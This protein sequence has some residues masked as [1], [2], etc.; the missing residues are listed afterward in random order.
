MGFL[1]RAGLVVGVIYMLSPVRE[2]GE[3]EAA[4]D[5]VRTHAE[6][7][8]AAALSYCVRNPEQCRA[9]PDRLEAVA[10]P[11]QPASRKTPAEARPAPAAR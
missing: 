8:G 1:L 10:G 3:V 11:G 2:G 6:G 5:L 9:A 7:A 4:R